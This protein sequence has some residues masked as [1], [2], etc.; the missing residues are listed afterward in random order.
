MIPSITCPELL[1]IHFGIVMVA[2]A[3]VLAYFPAKPRLLLVLV[4]RE[5][6]QL[7]QNASFLFLDDTKSA[8]DVQFHVALPLLVGSTAAQRMEWQFRRNSANNIVTTK[9]CALLGAGSTA[10]FCL[11]GVLVGQ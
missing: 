10:A 4:R 6:K 8:P 7:E 1:W 9:Q 5:E 2:L 3:L 11:G